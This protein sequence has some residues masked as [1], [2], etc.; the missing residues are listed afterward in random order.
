MCT[1]CLCQD[2]CVEL[3]KK[4]RIRMSIYKRKSMGCHSSREYQGMSL[5]MVWASTNK[6]FEW[7]SEEQ[8]CDIIKENNEII[9]LCRKV[10]HKA[11]PDKMG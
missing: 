10:K 7:T 8:M 5:E 2:E 9:R 3:Q 6:N 4:N 11:K 1:R